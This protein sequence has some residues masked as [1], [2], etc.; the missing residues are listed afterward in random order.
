MHDMLNETG[1]AELFLSSPAQFFAGSWY[2]MHHYPPERLAELQLSA[3]RLRFAQ[4]R[5]RI[6]TLSTMADELGVEYLDR[7]DAVVP[8]LFQHSVYKSYPLGLLERNRF[9]QLTRWLGGLTTVD[10]SAARVD[11]CESIDEWL[12][13]LDAQTELRVAHSSGTTGAMSF[14]P[15]SRSDW[16][17]MGEA[18]RCGLFQFSDPDGVEDHTGQ[19]F[20][21]I[22]PFHR[23]GRVGIARVP[24]LLMRHLVGSEDRIH[25]LHEGR[26]SSDAMFIAGRMR[27]AAAR[28]E[29]D[30]LEINPALRRRRD[31][32]EH[33]QRELQGSLPRFIDESVERFRGQRV[34]LMGTWNMLYGIAKAAL[35]RGVADVFAP[36]SVVTTGGGAKGQVVPEDWEEVVKR[37]VGVDHLQHA[38]SMTEMTGINKVCEHGHYHFEPW[39]IPF[40]MDPDDGRPLPRSGV[41]TGRAAF[42]DLLPES[43]W[44][45]FITGDEVTAH[46]EICPCGQTTAHIERQ[47]ERYSEK[48]GGDDKI[49]CAASDDAHTAALEFLTER[50]G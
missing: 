9:D 49:S 39:I 32:F 6:A 16:D 34:L 37:F 13:V 30:Q 10:L 2:A 48:R 29:L 28:G 40:V 11:D 45:G 47:I 43:Y 27:A 42:F 12:D 7:L 3:L 19:Y 14:I 15:R 46:W 36:D 17:R 50:L 31:E 20:D 35:G 33:Q 18:F 24:E 41:Q 21:L 26:L 23:H 4:Q 44:G 1:T 25:S 22:W 5:E 38:Y 8:L